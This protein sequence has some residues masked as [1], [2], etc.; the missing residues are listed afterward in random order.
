M[1]YIR[2]KN[3]TRDYESEWYTAK[4]YL[5]GEKNIL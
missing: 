4:E 1:Q 2:Q 5:K 3:L